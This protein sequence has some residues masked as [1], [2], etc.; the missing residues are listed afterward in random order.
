MNNEFQWKWAWIS[1]AISKHCDKKQEHSLFVSG[2]WNTIVVSVFIMIT[3][4]TTPDHEAQ[5]AMISKPI[6]NLL[7]LRLMTMTWFVQLNTNKSSFQ[8]S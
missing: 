1:N 2:V 7:F 6:N 8:Y 5:P 3:I 4:I